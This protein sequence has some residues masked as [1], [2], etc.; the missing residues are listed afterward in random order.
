M[1]YFRSNI[2]QLKEINNKETIKMLIIN[3]SNKEVFH[4]QNNSKLWK[5]IQNKD[6]ISKIIIIKMKNKRIQ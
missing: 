2:K 3:N 6:K 4:C 1:A 5:R